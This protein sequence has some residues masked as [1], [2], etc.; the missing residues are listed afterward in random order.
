MFYN[1]NNVL[2]ASDIEIIVNIKPFLEIITCTMFRWSIQEH[3]NLI[4]SYSWFV[5]FHVSFI[6]LSGVVYF[7]LDINLFRK[8]YFHVDLRPYKSIRITCIDN[9]VSWQ[10]LQLIY[11]F[12]KLNNH[13]H[14]IR[15]KVHV[16][17]IYLHLLLLF[18][19]K[20]IPAYLGI[21]LLYN[22]I[23]CFALSWPCCI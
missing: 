9:N 8:Q 15:Y 6:A 4:T 7:F 23:N 16:T 5:L 3:F 1:L 18:P 21:D 14:K 19:T 22:T 12:C 10:T 13:F 2:T 11:N 20:Q 17:C